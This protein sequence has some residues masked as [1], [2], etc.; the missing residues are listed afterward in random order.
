M[1]KR[2]AATVDIYNDDGVSFVC[3]AWEPSTYDGDE[4]KEIMTEIFGT[5]KALGRWGKQVSLT[6]L[7]TRLWQEGYRKV[8]WGDRWDKQPPRWAKK[9]IHTFNTDGYAVM[10]KHPRLQLEFK[11][12]N[13]ATLDEPW[14]VFDG[15]GWSNWYKTGAEAIRVRDNINRRLDEAEKQEAMCKKFE[16]LAGVVALVKLIFKKKGMNDPGYNFAVKE[17]SDYY[18]PEIAKGIVDY[19]MQWWINRIALLSPV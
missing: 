17:A 7:L 15:E 4:P 13:H 10:R 6:R 2:R 9:M 5:D 11:P 3:T 16:R 8:A 18:E 12:A 1:A 19:L 14:H